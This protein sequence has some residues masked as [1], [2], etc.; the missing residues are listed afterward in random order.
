MDI[1]NEITEGVYKFITSFVGLVIC[2]PVMVILTVLWIWYCM[3]VVKKL[4]FHVNAVT[5]RKTEKVVREGG[6]LSNLL[7][8]LTATENDI[9]MLFYIL[10]RSGITHD[11]MHH[12][13]NYKAY[14]HFNKKRRPMTH[15]IY[16]NI[17]FGIFAITL[18][19]FLLNLSGIDWSG[20]VL[21]VV[22]IF[23]FTLNFLVVCVVFIIANRQ[24][25]GY[26][27]EFKNCFVYLQKNSEN[28]FSQHNSDFAAFTVNI[29]NAIEDAGLTDFRVEKLINRYIESGTFI[30]RSEV[31]IPP[32]ARLPRDG[33]TVFSNRPLTAAEEA[34]SPVPA[35]ANGR[36]NTVYQSEN[37]MARMERM[38]GMMQ[39]GM[40]YNMQQYTMLNAQLAQSQ[41]AQYN[42]I[43]QPSLQQ[44]MMQNQIMMQNAQ[45][46][47]M[48]SHRNL[49]MAG[50]PPPRFRSPQ[51]VVIEEGGVRSLP[52]PPK[53]VNKPNISVTIERPVEPKAEPEFTK[54]ELLAEAREQLKQEAEIADAKE[55][56]VKQQEIAARPPKITGREVTYKPFKR[57]NERFRKDNPA[58]YSDK[59]FSA[60]VVFLEPKREPDK[61][62]DRLTRIFNAKVIKYLPD[63]WEELRYT[64]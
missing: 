48:V 29:A 6:S 16:L 8:I 35:G 37:E 43:V 32:K 57:L 19:A 25:S 38:V 34:A 23:A 28:Y 5:L 17:C 51:E 18:I 39:H 1:F 9:V 49:M 56:E 26:W 24:V 33:A 7:D 3:L 31:G 54:E 62:E 64:D 58:L 14:K 36:P 55:K 63:E 50:A 44:H 20:S 2:I 59:A 53:S 12:Y 61:I 42:Q 30:K 21:P 27:Q 10:C 45:M 40:Q 46:Q 22:S 15:A 41:I 4:K 47:N 60:P 52:T 13:L 11:K